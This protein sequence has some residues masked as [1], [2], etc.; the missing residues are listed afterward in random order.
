MRTPYWKIILVAG[1][2]GFAIGAVAQIHAQTTTQTSTTCHLNA[3]GNGLD[4]E[5]HPTFDIT[6]STSTTCSAYGATLDCTSSPTFGPV[7]S[8][9]ERQQRLHDE[10]AGA[11]AIGR[12][13]AGI[14]HAINRSHERSRLKDLGVR[15][16]VLRNDIVYGDSLVTRAT[17]RGDTAAVRRLAADQVTLRSQYGQMLDSLGIRNHTEGLAPLP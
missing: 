14:F 13:V 8:T 3:A 16:G 15:A 5:S 4:C 9:A 6:Q 17:V 10:A 11:V 7:E 12:G 2:L 1:S